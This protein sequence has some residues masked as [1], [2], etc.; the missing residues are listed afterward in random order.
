MSVN[1][2]QQHIV[3]NPQ[4]LPSISEGNSS[5][6]SVKLTALQTNIAKELEVTSSMV[7]KTT[8]SKRVV[9]LQTLQKTLEDSSG[10]KVDLNKVESFLKDLPESTQKLFKEYLGLFAELPKQEESKWKLTQEEFE[11]I[12]MQGQPSRIG[13]GSFGDV[14][15]SADGKYVFKIPK[16]RNI[17]EDKEKNEALNRN[18]QAFDPNQFYYRQ[19]DDV[20]TRYVGTFMLGKKEVSVFEKIDGQDFSQC[21]DD[22]A[23]VKSNLEKIYGK[24]LNQYNVPILK[25]A[26]LSRLFAQA[27]T[28]IAI[29][30]DA[31]CV[32][33]DVKPQNM[34][35]TKD[36]SLLKLIDQGG[37]IDLTQG[38]SSFTTWTSAF[39][40]PEV[41]SSLKNRGN[42]QKVTPACDVYSMGI[43]ILTKL[44][45]IAEDS[46]IARKAEE[47][48][49]NLNGEFRLG[50]H[51]EYREELAT[52]ILPLCVEHKVI[53]GDDAGCMFIGLLL[54]DCLAFNPEDRIS[55]AQAAEI[56]QV[57]SSYLEE[58]SKNPNVECP[59]YDA[60]KTMALKDCPKSIPV[61]IRKMLLNADSEIQLDAVRII[62]QLAYADKSY[63]NTPSC[64]LSMA[65]GIGYYERYEKDTFE[66]WVKEH[67]ESAQELRERIYV[68]DQAHSDKQD[69]PVS[70]EIYKIINDKL[71]ETPS[72][73]ERS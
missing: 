7:D 43:S 15:G 62:G 63:V 46:T 35:V 60:V 47:I 20:I 21:F 65:L 9:A 66:Y 16:K 4:E 55:A 52:D 33:S 5:A 45:S 69:M 24:V 25:C 28:A 73:I 71:V 42:P 72:E 50:S 49:R 2:T 1:E 38:N 22:Q 11:K 13:S 41:L 32:N 3:T 40:A 59:N 54:S 68:R 14:Y 17:S 12:L 6:R 57:F 64:G 26:Q 58:K 56:L 37:I 36:L 34:M 48:L 10:D 23:S 30:H 39:A 8:Q 18:A 29:S 67:P 31:G 53:P 44:E 19:K 51:S 61:V 70:E 27:A